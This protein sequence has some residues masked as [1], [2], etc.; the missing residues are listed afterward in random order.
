MSDNAD[1]PVERTARVIA[2]SMELHY[3]WDQLADLLKDYYRRSARAVLDDFAA[4][5][6]D[7]AES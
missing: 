2:G 6:G 7:G 5:D 4:A 3:S 1:D